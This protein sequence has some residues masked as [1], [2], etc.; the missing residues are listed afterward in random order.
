MNANAN[1]YARFEAGFDPEAVFL[2]VPGGRSYTY[3][4][5]DAN[6]ARAANQLHALGL[7]PGD[8]VSALAEKSPALLWLYLGCLRAGCIY[9]PLNPSYTENE[10]GFFLRDA[11]TRLVICDPALEVRAR[12][13]SAG[14]RELEHVLTL[15]G[16]ADG[17]FSA[18]SAAA[19]TSFTTHVAGERDTAA[20]LYSSGTTGTPKGI[21]LTHRNL[22]ANAEVLMRTWAFSRDDVLLHV[23]PIYHVHG[24]FVILGPALLAGSRVRFLP[25]FDIDAVIE[26]LPGASVMAGV[27]TYYTRLLGS[28]KFAR[29]ACA[30]VRVFISGSAPL[31][32]ATFSQFHERAG[33]AILERYGM[34]ETGILSSNPLSGPRKPGSVGPALDGVELRVVDDGGAASARGD[35]G[36]IEV[37]GDNVF[38]GYR[39]L[40]EANREA[41]RADGYFRT[42]DQGYL[43]DDGYLF[44][45]GRSK[46]IIISGGLNVYPKE[47][48]REIDALPDVVESAVFGVPHPDFG[49]ATVA[50]IVPDAGAACDEAAMLA[51]LKTKLAG[52]KIPKRFVTFTELP[53]NAMGKVQKNRLREQFNDLFVDD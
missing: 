11:Q 26:A 33:H 17:D 22:Y 8:C 21:P 7:A 15:G 28:D 39:H 44:I 41:F 38:A 13:A 5:L 35:T 12:A 14:C 9:H 4:D 29:E 46:D 37:R 18:R 27:P 1:I 48:E 23:L 20:M 42:G 25:R 32:E 49:E 34:T 19:S 40:A 45:V 10:I 52:Y 30:S 3:A 43:D 51:V 24:L 53:R 16:G 2:E 47:V 36:Q 50:A 6:S 31:S